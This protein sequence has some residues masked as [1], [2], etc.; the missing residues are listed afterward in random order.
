[1]RRRVFS[2]ALLLLGL[3]LL[4]ACGAAR[5]P[6]VNLRLASDF[7]PGGTV[8][9]RFWSPGAGGENLSPPLRWSGVPAGTESFALTVEDLSP[10]ANDWAH[11]LV[12]NIP[13]RTRSLPAGASGAKALPPGSKELVNSFG[14]AGYGGPEPPPGTGRHPYRFT[15]YALRVR[16]LNLPPD[17]GLSGLRAA[18]AGKV[19]ARAELTGYAGD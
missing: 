6:K 7:P 8:P 19:L 15:L 16:R 2:L 10:V 4:T 12:V 1:M 13:G 3:S 18:L 11:W 5:A 9:R 14:Y 17:A